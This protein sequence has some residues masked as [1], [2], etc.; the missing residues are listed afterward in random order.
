MLKHRTPVSRKHT[1]ALKTKPKVMRDIKQQRRESSLNESIETTM[2]MDSSTSLDDSFAL[3]APTELSNYLSD[4]S[5]EEE[6]EDDDYY[7]ELSDEERS[8]IY[9]DWLSELELEDIKMLSMLL[10]DNYRNRFGLLKTFAA[11]EVALCLGCGDKTVRR[12]RKQNRFVKNICCQGSGPMFG[13][14]R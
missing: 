8:S 12:W 7:G 6:A 3:P 14:W 11:K 1:K 5:S 10:Y 9:K 13:M 4:V 2:E